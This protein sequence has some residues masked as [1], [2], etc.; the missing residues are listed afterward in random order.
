MIAKSRK[1]VPIRDIATAIKAAPSSDEVQKTSF[2]IFYNPLF[3]RFTW[4][5]LTADSSLQ[6]ARVNSFCQYD[7]VPRRQSANP[8]AQEVAIEHTIHLHVV[9]IAGYNPAAIPESTRMA[10]RLCESYVVAVAIRQGEGK[11][12]RAIE[13]D[14][15]RVDTVIFEGKGAA[16]AQARHATAHGVGG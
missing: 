7:I 11:A 16:M 9:D 12:E 14:D 2:C 4:I 15:F 8:T 3:F 1:K 10:G 5:P 13:K 6:L